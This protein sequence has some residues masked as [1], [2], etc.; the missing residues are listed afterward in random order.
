[1]NDVHPK[2][3]NLLKIVFSVK[4]LYLEITFDRILN[5][6]RHNLRTAYLQG[7]HLEL[8]SKELNHLA[9]ILHAYAGG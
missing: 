2:K 3:I 7:S 9:A 8:V 5:F 6:F 1:M 4:T